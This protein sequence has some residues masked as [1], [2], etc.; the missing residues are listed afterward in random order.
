MDRD[1]ILLTPGPLTTTLRTKLAM[2]KDWGS[3]DSD[4]NAVTASVRKSLLAVIH[5]QESHVVVPLQGSAWAAPLSA[6]KRQ[7]PPWCRVTAT[8]W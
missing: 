5:G 2:L 6:W 1:K 3:W 8:C 7:W 4:F